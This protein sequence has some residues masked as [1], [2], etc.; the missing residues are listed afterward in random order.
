MAFID[1]ILQKP[2]YG[3]TN[4]E[5]ELSVPSFRQL[6]KEAFSR[7]NIFKTRK[8]WISL[9]SWLMAACML[10]FFIFFLVV[11]FSWPLAIAVVVYSMI[12]MGTHGTIWFHRYCTHNSY[13]FRHPIWRFLTQNLV[14][15]TFPEEIYVVSHHVH[16]AK[17]DQPGDPYNAQGGFWYCMLS[18]VNHQSI[19][20]DLDEVTYGKVAR[21]MRH[22]GVRLNTYSQ[23]LKWGSVASPL[24]TVLLWLFNWVAWYTIFYL[25]GGHALACALFSAAMLWFILVRA[26]NYTGHGKGKEEHKEGVDFDR[27]NL[28]VNQLRPGLFAGEWHNNHHLYPGSARAGFLPYQLDLAWIYIFVLYKLGAVSSF[29]DSKKEF[30]RRYGSGNKND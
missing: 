20:K 9:I 18:D 6:F 29:H 19:A 25:I 4:A 23:Y 28:S 1:E 24:Y 27:S 15:K 11:H 22:T 21:F 14:I 3:W 5:G 2:S 10:P 17:S 12:I 16:H 13:K 8:N 30:L 7:I 26:F